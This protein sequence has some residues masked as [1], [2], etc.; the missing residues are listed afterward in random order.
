MA[1]CFCIIAEFLLSFLGM[2]NKS[3]SKGLAPGVGF[4]LAPTRSRGA[5]HRKLALARFRLAPFESLLPSK[6][7]KKKRI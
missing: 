3:L 7:S 5:T 4:L 1:Y 2:K 6:K